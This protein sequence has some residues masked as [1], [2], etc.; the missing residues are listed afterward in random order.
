MRRFKGRVVRANA[1]AR[2]SLPKFRLRLRSTRPSDWPPHLVRAWQIVNGT[3]GLSDG[4]ALSVMLD[5]VSAAHGCVVAENQGVNQIEEREALKKVRKACKRALERIEDAPSD[6]SAKLRRRL[7]KEI[8]PLIREPV[9]D[10][11]VI[12]SIFEAAA[13]VFGEFPNRGR[14]LLPICCTKCERSA[15]QRLARHC[16]ASWSWR[17]PT[18]ENHQQ[19]NVQMRYRSSKRLWVYYLPRKRQKLR[20]ALTS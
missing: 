9:I 11:E 7:D 17:L 15:F 5:S 12:Q 4:E 8:R 18:L 13:G 20:P 6:V 2:R 1:F 19:Q 14:S 3:L 16:V 10:L